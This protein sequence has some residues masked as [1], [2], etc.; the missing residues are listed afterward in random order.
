MQLA[1]QVLWSSLQ[2]EWTRGI[3]A[4]NAKWQEWKAFFLDV[5]N[6]ASN[7]V[8][9]IFVE[10]FAAIQR[11]WLAA[12]DFMSAALSGFTTAFINFWADINSLIQKAIVLVKALF[13]ESI[14]VSDEFER[15]N[16]NV[17]Q[18]RESRNAALEAELVERQQTR[19]DAIA[20]I[21]ESRQL[22]REALRD[23][24][25]AESD[26]LAREQLASI[27]ASEDKLQQARDRF[28]EATKKAADVAKSAVAEPE[29][30]DLSGVLP[31]DFFADISHAVADQ[32]GR[33]Q[34]TFV[35]ALA[36]RSIG[37]VSPEDR[38]LAELRKI[39]RGQNE[40][41]DA[42]RDNKLELVF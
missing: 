18:L 23:Q 5:V 2:L 12:V 9:V 30:I 11:A 16:R 13:D 32:I 28:A 4:L 24:R 20:K 25:A 42:I 40:V 37:F 29:I 14:S 21:E 34:G 27:R 31:S 1:A 6:N 15:I 3:A 8:A 22:R 33:V 39:A 41:I 7:A 19:T 36:A 38:Q 26:R 35:G 17:R 10:A